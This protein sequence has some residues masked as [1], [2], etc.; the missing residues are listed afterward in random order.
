MHP[1]KTES[2]P[3]SGILRNLP[4][5]RGLNGTYSVNLGW[6][7]PSLFACAVDFQIVVGNGLPNYGW[8]GSCT[9]PL[10]NQYGVNSQGFVAGY[11]NGEFIDIANDT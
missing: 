5:A 7:Y 1:T 8:T 9:S 3:V 11:L 2:V 4:S 10:S 6:L